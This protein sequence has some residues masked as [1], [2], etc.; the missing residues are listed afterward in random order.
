MSCDAC[1]EAAT[2]PPATVTTDAAGGVRHRT[3]CQGC[4][5]GAAARPRQPVRMCVR[6]ERITSAPVL[7]AEVHQGTGPGFNVYACPDCAPRLP[8][9]PD[10]LDLLG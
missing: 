3:V 2:G 8:E 7:V 10:A 4:A 5:A 1:G 9:L 6:C